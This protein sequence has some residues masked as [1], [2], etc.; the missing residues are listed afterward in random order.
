VAAAAEF[1]VG[2]AGEARGGSVGQ[3]VRHV[4]AGGLPVGQLDRALRVDKTS[5][6]AGEPILVEMHVHTEAGCRWNEPVGGNYRGLGRDDNFL[7]LVRRSDGSWVD[8]PY[9]S[10]QVF[11]GGGLSSTVA[12]E[13]GKP[14]SHWLAVQRWAAI[15]KLGR[16]ER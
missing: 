6:V 4:A 14:F 3:A 12:V 11:I 1:T 8:D 15:E 13:H 5:L 10:Q 16:Y 2:A 9:G 7:F